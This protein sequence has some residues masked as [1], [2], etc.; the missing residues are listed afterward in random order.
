MAKQQRMK[1]EKL[2][3]RLELANMKD[4]LKR[5]TLR[6]TVYTQSFNDQYKHAGDY[7]LVIVCNIHC[8]FKNFLP[9]SVDRI[10]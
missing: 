2:Y 6:S 3:L 1:V 10:K 8:M 4:S 7:C 9:C 5:Y